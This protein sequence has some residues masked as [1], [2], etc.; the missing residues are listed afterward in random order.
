MKHLETLV[1]EY[2]HYAAVD[3]DTSIQIGPYSGRG[4]YGNQ[5]LS[6]SGDLVDIDSIIME[7]IGNYVNDAK[8]T[9]LQGI[10]TQCEQDIKDGTILLDNINN[11]LELLI[12]DRKQD[13]LGRQH[14]V[15]FPSQEWTS[16]FDEYKYPLTE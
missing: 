10:D 2:L 14:V 15:Y 16:A 7:A 13:T 8:E 12:H 3:R 1:A 9:I 4:M 6:I 11:I 5:C